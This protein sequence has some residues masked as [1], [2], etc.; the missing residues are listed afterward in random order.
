MNCHPRAFAQ[1]LK[2]DLMDS[3]KIQIMIIVLQIIIVILTFL[4]KA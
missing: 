3:N 2:R 1:V 4:L